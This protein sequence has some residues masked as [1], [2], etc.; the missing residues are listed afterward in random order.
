MTRYLFDNATIVTLDPEDHIYDRGQLAI[1]GETILSVGR[2]PD[3]FQ[4]DERIDLGGRVVMPGLYNAHTH[5][6]MT[7]ARGYA[8]DLPLERWFNER[9]WR[10]ESALTPEIVYWGTAL[11][12]VEMIRGGIVGF[13]DMYFHMDQVARVVEESGMRATLAW[14]VFGQGEEVG[15]TVPETVDFVHHHNGAAGGRLRAL[16]GPH[17]PYMCPDAFLARTA[18]VA[19]R[20][21]IG[22]HIHVAETP[23][24]VKLAWDQYDMSPVELLGNRGLFE[25]HTIVAHAIHVNEVDITTL[26]NKQVH[27]VQCPSTY[28]RYAMGVAPVPEMLAR[29]VNVALGTDGAGSSVA[30]NMWRE[31]RL[32]VLMQ[33]QAHG[34]PT[35]M[36]GSLPLHMAAANGARALGFPQSGVLAPGNAADLIVIDTTAPHFQPLHDV[37]AG[38]VWCTEPADVRDVMVAGRWLMRDRNLLTLDEEAILSGFREALSEMLGRPLGQFR[39]YDVG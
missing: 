20:E 27:V 32:A 21:G 24:Q 19:Y 3:D 15:I 17:S 13:G 6:A 12:A 33:R 39:T 2:A 35:L 38:L 7:F 28:L 16:F 26:A 8:E 29:G 10:L 1:E 34:D 11:A 25:T 23:E 22:I 37:I 36:P 4:P 31:M 18:A 14:T 9:I 5:A 30:L